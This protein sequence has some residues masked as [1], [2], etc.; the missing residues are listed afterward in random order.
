MKLAITNGTIIDGTGAPPRSGSVVVTNDRITAILTKNDPVPMVD[1]TIDAKGGTI[2]PGLIDAHDHQTYHNTFGVLQ[3]QWTLPRDQLIIRSCI[4]AL[5]ALRHGVTTIREMGAAGATNFSIKKAM[6]SGDLIGPRIFTCGMPLTI[7]GGYAYWICT[8]A[9][10]PEGVRTAVRQQLKNGA[11]FIKL[12]ASNEKP[13]PG[14]QEQSLAQFTEEELRVAVDEA[15]AAGVKVAVHACGSKAIERCLDAG[16]DTI[17]HGVY[18][19]RDLAQR[20]KEQ[21]TYY[22]PTL[23]IYEFDTDLFWRRG[24]TKAEFCRILMKAHREHFETIHD[25]GLKWTLGT[26]AIVPIA[27][28]MQKLVEAGLDPMTVIV[29]ATRTNAEMIGRSEDLGTLEVGKLADILIVDGNPL[30]KMSDMANVKVILQGGKIYCP[31]QLLPML[32][33]MQPPLLGET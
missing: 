6:A 31:D 5:D 28:E 11:D 19:N 3:W 23:G 4:A 20:M 27:T 12:M 2:L 21:G 17:E 22:S 30:K 9:D 18:L 10:G 33:F 26:D 1:Q 24:K 25:I 7:T 16:V 32:P 8:E 13:L 15:H 29:S 14:R